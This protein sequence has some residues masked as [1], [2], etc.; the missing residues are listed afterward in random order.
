M[1]NRSNW[2]FALAMA[3]ALPATATQAADISD[4]EV[5]IGLISDMMS[6]YRSVGRGA[7]AAA[8]MAIEDFGG[9][10][11]GK[12]IRL[13]V[14]D[15]KIDAEVAMQHAKELHEQH[16]ID[17]FLE[18][19]GTAVAVPLQRYAK[20]NNIA[21]LHTGTASSILTG[22]ECSPVG[23]HWVYDTYALAA[24]TAAA[25]MKQGGDSWFFITADNTFGKVLQADAANVINRMGG[26]VVG[27]AYH[28]FKAK[29][30]T[31]QLLQ[32]KASGAKVIG[33]ATAGDD[34]NALLRQAYELDMMNGEQ[35]IA[36]LLVAEEV[37]RQVGMYV[38]GGLKLTTGWNWK[39]DAETRAW[40]D[41]F[42]KRTGLGSSMYSVGVYSVVLHYLKAIEAAGTDD[43]KVVVAKMRE[44]PVNDVFTRN[45]KLR[46]DGRMVH[47]MFLAEVKRATE[48]R[49]AFDYYN[50]LDV[51]PGD[52]AFRPME[53]GGCPLV[54]TAK[55]G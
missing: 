51:I 52:Q 7:E 49:E 1:K 43:A 18:M 53:E 8:E 31:A 42:R 2:F 22:P 13:Y 20:A 46:I 44:I 26:K 48:S 17:A 21:A 45:G 10:V 12:P 33:L 15:H 6:I 41:R 19:V 37:P 16:H 29:D 27:T 23:V 54:K 28:P 39:Q 25:I 36:G 40:T 3:I 38:S 24:G 34:L 55:K 30:Y 50:I 4:G 32:A 9:K 47:D 11:L 14:R 35:T 5:R